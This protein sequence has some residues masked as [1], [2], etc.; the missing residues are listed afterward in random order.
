MPRVTTLLPV[1]RFKVPGAVIP[2]DLEF[3]FETDLSED[4][5]IAAC[6]NADFLFVPANYP[7]IT[8]RIRQRNKEWKL[9]RSEKGLL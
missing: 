5:I 9:F 1:E 4:A 2:G 8:D 3:Q 7:P 6:R